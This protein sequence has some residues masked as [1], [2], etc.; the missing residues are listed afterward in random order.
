MPWIYLRRDELGVSAEDAAVLES[1]YRFA[2]ITNQR[3]TGSA[4][5][6]LATLEHH[7]IPVLL[8]KGLPLLAEAYQDIGG[9]YMEDFDIMLR[10]EHVEPAVAALA[11][12]GWKP[13]RPEAFSVSA[14]RWRHSEELTHLSGLS[15]DIHWRLLCRP[16][17]PVDEE[18]VWASRRTILL[19]DRPALTLSPEHML[20]H[21]LVH[22]LS[23]ER[24]PAIRWILD[25][26]L[27]LRRHTPDWPHVA[28]EAARRGVTLLVADA[29]AVYDEILPGEIPA[30]IR[31]ELARHPVS[32]R[33]RRA[34]EQLT[35]P[36]EST[37]L[38][39][40][41]DLYL[42]DWTRARALE[43]VP[44]G[45]RGFLQHLKTYWRVTSIFAL[46]WTF[47]RKVLSRAKR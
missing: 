20:V 33:Q 14:R 23:W 10:D 35:R 27:L 3:L 45:L 12:S 13:A 21:G 34:Y 24:V 11:E 1:I 18:P 44:P 42:S 6:V 47:L 37:S 29:M 7:Q 15:C 2:W 19:R 40:A 8:L 25:T 31:R 41:W 22:G 5:A 43:E 32:G 30:E 38:R 36:Y 46:P 9:R 4:L 17:E 26:H 16:N 28:A 39:M